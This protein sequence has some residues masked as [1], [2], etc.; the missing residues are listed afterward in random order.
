MTVRTIKII[1]RWNVILSVIGLIMFNEPL[2]FITC[3]FIGVL[4]CIFLTILSLLEQ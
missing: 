3:G 2:Y 4:S 1:F